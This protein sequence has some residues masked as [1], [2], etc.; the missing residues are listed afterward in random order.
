MLIKSTDHWHVSSVHSFSS[1]LYFHIVS[2]CLY[3]LHEGNKNRVPSSP[4]T[5]VPNHTSPYFCWALMRKSISFAKQSGRLPQRRG[6]MESDGWPPIP[7]I[8]GQSIITPP[9]SIAA[10]ITSRCQ[11]LRAVLWLLQEECVVIFLC[12]PVSLLMFCRCMSECIFHC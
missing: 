2:A 1:L 11:P 9:V 5:R 12:V 7:G 3:L 4:F 6:V 8:M 10:S